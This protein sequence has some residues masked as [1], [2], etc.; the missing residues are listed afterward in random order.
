MFLSILRAGCQRCKA[1]GSFDSH[2]EEIQ[3]HQIIK[4]QT[5]K[6]VSEEEGISPTWCCFSGVPPANDVK[7]KLHKTANMKLCFFLTSLFNL[8]YIKSV[9]KI[10]KV[11]KGWRSISVCGM[12]LEHCVLCRSVCICVSC[13]H[14]A[15][16]FG[17]LCALLAG[18]GGG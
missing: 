8:Y 11:E 18:F 12:Y 14:A 3:D 6:L 13:T 1:D 10:S 16:M 4:S 15:C 2:W 7:T 9:G 5:L 17:R